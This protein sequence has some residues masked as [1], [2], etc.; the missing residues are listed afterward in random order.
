[1]G[2]S[3][4]Q[5]VNFQM[6]AKWPILEVTSLMTWF[7]AAYSRPFVSRQNERV[8]GFRKTQTRARHT[9][10]PIQIG[11]NII[12]KDSNTANMDKWA[13]L[14]YT[15]DILGLLMGIQGLT[16][17]WQISSFYLDDISPFDY[18]KAH[19][20]M[21]ASECNELNILQTSDELFGGYEVLNSAVIR[22]ARETIQMIN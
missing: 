20:N 18:C 11:I 4:G 8:F 10:Y 17:Y 3:T 21:F 9:L 16:F 6:I 19:L 1:M 22:F 5:I 15:K 7:I 12:L 2:L 14:R 13:F